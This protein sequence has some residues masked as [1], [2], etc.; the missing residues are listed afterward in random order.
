[1]EDGRTTEVEHEIVGRFQ[2]FQKGSKVSRIPTKLGTDLPTTFGDDMEGQFFG[3]CG[4]KGFSGDAKW[5]DAKC[6]KWGY[7]TGRENF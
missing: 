3:K 4:C 5:T 7:G 6:A 1:M 2:K